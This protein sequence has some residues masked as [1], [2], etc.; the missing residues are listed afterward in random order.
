MQSGQAK[1][2]IALTQYLAD[3]DSFPRNAVATLAAIASNAP[4]HTKWNKTNTQRNEKSLVMVVQISTVE[5]I[6]FFAP[7]TSDRVSVEDV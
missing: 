2:P 3:A 6:I 7:L 1:S 4:C 5:S